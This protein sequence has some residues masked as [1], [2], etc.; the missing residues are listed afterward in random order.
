MVSERSTGRLVHAVFRDLPELLPPGSLLTLSRSGT[1][2]PELP[3]LR[4]D[5]SP[6]LAH[7]STPL[8]RAED[9]LWTLELRTPSGARFGGGRIGDVLFLPAGGTARILDAYPAPDSV[10][11]EGSRL[12][13]ARLH[14]PEP[15][16]PYLARH[17]RPIRYGHIAGEWPLAAYQTAYADVPGS[18]EMP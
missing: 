7:L 18:A 13:T 17:G 4:A 10:V 1:R 9:R 3:A 2:P 16:L 15:L 5:G 6:L 14:L 12:W 8:P 11:I